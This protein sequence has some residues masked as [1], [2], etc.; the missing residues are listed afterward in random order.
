MMVI[1]ITITKMI[2][3]DF[4]LMFRIADDVDDNGQLL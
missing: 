4:I 2:M 1:I 3:M